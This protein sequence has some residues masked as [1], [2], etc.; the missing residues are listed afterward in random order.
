MS[1]R[2]KR[3]FEGSAADDF[4]AK[5][6]MSDA[7]LLQFIEGATTAEETS[8]IQ[9][10]L[11]TCAICSHIV[12]SVY[13]NKTHP[14]TDDE[15]REAQELIQHTPEEQAAKL[16]H[17]FM[18]TKAAHGA[19]IRAVP[20]S[21]TERFR[22]SLE[23]LPR[24]PLWQP[25][26]AAV[27]VLLALGGRWTY[28]YVQT[29]YKIEQAAGLLKQEHS[30]YFKDPR[31]SGGYSASRIGT[32]M[33]EEQ[34]EKYSVRA[35]KLAAAAIANGAESLKAKQLLAQSLFIEKKYERLD[36]LLREIAPLAENS[37]ALLNDLGV[38][39][40][41]KQDWG[42]AEE[43][44][45]AAITRDPKFLEARYNLALTKAERG[46]R[47]E[48]IKLMQEYLALETDEN[49]KIAAQSLIKNDWQ[50]EE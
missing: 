4:S 11:N 5:N 16:L 3:Q 27:L 17:G 14:F 37:A 15:R 32:L 8:K 12:G 40:F 26:F 45:F 42:S 13:Y 49:W 36:S 20:R 46:A 7:L 6:C 38:Y 19:P 29:D 34:E 50:L 23:W 39:F 41:Q 48:A 44:F 10:H 25:A 35:E 28:R 47:E 33:G 2:I 21:Q 43:Y 1:D 9:A 22:L 18:E 30:V 31:L 24:L